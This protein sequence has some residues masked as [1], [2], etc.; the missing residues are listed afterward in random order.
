MKKT[1]SLVDNRVCSKVEICE[2][3]DQTLLGR[4]IASGSIE[5]S[6]LLNYVHMLVSKIFIL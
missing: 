5:L 3:L 6:M 4:R 2:I 1:N